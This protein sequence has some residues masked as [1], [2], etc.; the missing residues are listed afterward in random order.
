[1]ADKDQ[2]GPLGENERSFKDEDGRQPDLFS[3]NDRE[4]VPAKESSKPDQLADDPR[5]LE[6]GEAGGY[7]TDT[8]SRG[9]EE[10]VPQEDLGNEA[11]GAKGVSSAEDRPD[12]TRKRAR[13]D[14]DSRDAPPA[15]PRE[16]GVR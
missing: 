5:V 1:M 8:F 9:D 2:A 3:R 15:P 16:G 10:G 14:A 7:Q 4:G 6:A 13:D 12:D 11:A